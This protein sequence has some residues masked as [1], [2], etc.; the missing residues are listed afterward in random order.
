VAVGVFF[1]AA[2]GFTWVLT[3]LSFAYVATQRKGRILVGCAAFY[4]VLSLLLILIREQGLTMWL[5]SEYHVF[6]FW[7]MT[8]VFAV[9]WDLITTPPGRICAFLSRLRA[10]AGAI[11]AV[12]VLFRFFPTLRAELRAVRESL[13]NRGLTTARRLALHPLAYFEYLLIP[14]LMRCLRTADQLAV[15]A[16]ARG[17]EA[18]GI[19]SS[20]DEDSLRPRDA[21]CAALVSVCLVGFLIVGKIG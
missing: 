21:A 15:S 3:L 9:S 12:L 6:L 20:Y 2:P 17:I 16:V 10:P 11:V 19:R 5:F 1:S 8:G 18:P 7:V 14:L 4:G 13:H